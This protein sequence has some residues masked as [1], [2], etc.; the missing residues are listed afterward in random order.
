MSENLLNSKPSTGADH[1][2]LPAETVKVDEPNP[3]AVTRGTASMGVIHRLFKQVEIPF[4]MLLLLLMVLGFFVP[5]TM[6]AYHH[7]FLGESARQPHSVQNAGKVMS[8]HQGGGWIT[9]ALVETDLGY[10]AL[11]DGISLNKNE[12]LTLETRDDKVR[13]L[14]D[15]QHRCQ[16]LVAQRQAQ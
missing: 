8:I 6:Y 14:C 12:A 15:S 9:R 13:F 10:Y 4:L 3:S 2:L 16:S 7:V 11:T 5:M 1:S